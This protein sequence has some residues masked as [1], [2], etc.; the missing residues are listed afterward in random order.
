MPRAWRCTSTPR[1]PRWRRRPSA[2][3]TQAAAAVRAFDMA[4]GTSLMQ[5]D[6]PFYGSTK[7]TDFSGRPSGLGSAAPLA[8]GLGGDPPRPRRAPPDASARVM[9]LGPV[10]GRDGARGTAP[11]HGRRAAARLAS[12]RR[13]GA[14]PSPSCRRRRVPS[15]GGEPRSRTRCRTPTRCRSP[16]HNRR[17]RR[18][19]RSSP[20]RIG[21]GRR[22]E[23]RAAGKSRA[24]G[25]RAV[26]NTRSGAVS[27][28]G[29]PAPVAPARSSGGASSSPPAAAGAD[30]VRGAAMIAPNLPRPSATPAQP[31]RPIP[32]HLVSRAA[33]E[34][35][36]ARLIAKG[37]QS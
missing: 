2:S 5:P 23:F 8:R 32:I 14:C 4:A 34:D 19:S 10:P 6:H 9:S 24:E 20:A 29:E 22:H 18:G 33:V 25:Q 16:G 36:V 13:A 17:R 35:L 26:P 31:A 12:P 30:L 11:R 15:R 28:S 1:W 21:E 3:S 27:P 7:P 37:S